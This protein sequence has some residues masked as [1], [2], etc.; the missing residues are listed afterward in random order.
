M[1]S[2][3]LPGLFNTG[4]AGC[5]NSEDMPVTRY[6]LNQ[7]NTI[8]E[9]RSQLELRDA[10]TFTMNEMNRFRT[11]VDNR[12]ERV[13]GAIAQQAVHN[14]TSDGVIGCLTQQVASLNALTKCIIPADNICPP[15]MPLYNSWTAPTAPTTAG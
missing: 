4:R 15:P 8:S 6:E 2:G 11:Y 5:C 1:N 9:L 3:I 12:F 10:N 7:Q 14:A 13:E